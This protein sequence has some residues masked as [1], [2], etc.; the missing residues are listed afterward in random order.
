MAEEISMSGSLED[1]PRKIEEKVSTSDFFDD[2]GKFIPK[3]LGDEIGGRFHFKTTSDNG[4]IYVYE[5]G[6]YKPEGETIIKQSVNALLGDK[7]STHRLN[8][9]ISYIQTSTFVKRNSPDKELINLTNGFYN[10]TTGKI[11]PHDPEIFSIAQHPF[12][13]EEGADCPAIKKFVSEIVRAGDVP[14]IQEWFGYCLWREYYIQKACMLIGEG[15]NGKSTLFDLFTIFLGKG[16]VSS[17]GLQDLEK[18]FTSSN[19]Y[20]KLANIY[21]DLPDVALKYTGKFKML[22]G[23]DNISAE[24]KFKD[25]FN[26]VNYAKLMFSANKLPETSDDTTAF[27]R[28]WLF[29]SF[30]N[31]FDGT[32]RDLHILEKLTTDSEL[33]GLFNWAI[34]GLKRLLSV[35]DFSASISTE[36]TRDQYIRMSSPVAAFVK[37]C[38]EFRSDGIITKENMY[39][40]YL[41]YCEKNNLPT[42]PSN[43]FALKL[44][45]H[46]PNISTRKARA[47]EGRKYCWVGVQVVHVGHAFTYFSSI[48]PHGSKR[49]KTLDHLDHL[50]HPNLNKFLKKNFTE[51]EEH[52]REE[53]EKILFGWN[54]DIDKLKEEGIIFEPTPGRF[55]LT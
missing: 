37:D 6:V 20:G 2:A 51:K 22:T 25:F 29:L 10:I 33:S 26:F 34:E 38:L 16:N 46:F 28:R 44:K 47:G 32:K 9:T 17:I 3:R 49:R 19:L 24:Q 45:Q 30:P 42:L 4:V 35:G 31:R 55:R 36:E 39:N 27:Y 23:G 48:S 13:Y 54:V 12:S 1:E 21:A 8:E 41:R 52:K 11:E 7:Y 40:G 53:L 14:V 15:N 43:T 18:R 5:N 50:D